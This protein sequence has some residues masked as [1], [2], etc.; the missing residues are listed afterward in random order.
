VKKL[1]FAESISCFI[2]IVHIDEINNKRTNTYI[3]HK[4]SFNSMVFN[5]NS[6]YMYRRRRN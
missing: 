1:V 4:E 6:N 3:Y 5:M 2:Y